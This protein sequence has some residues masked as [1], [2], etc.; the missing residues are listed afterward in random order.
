M[1]FSCAQKQKMLSYWKDI[2]RLFEISSAL[3][4]LKQSS[5]KKR[6]ST[7]NSLKH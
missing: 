1:I 7:L 5:E 6:W 3:K 4:D 2:L